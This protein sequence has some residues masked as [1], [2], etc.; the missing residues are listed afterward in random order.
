MHYAVELKK[1]ITEAQVYGVHSGRQ[2]KISP[3]G[4]GF[5]RIHVASARGES[6]APITFRLANATK[7]EIQG[8]SL[9][10]VYNDVYYGAILELH[11]DR[12]FFISESKAYQERFTQNI[13]EA[14]FG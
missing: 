6:P 2:Y 4:F 7:T 5:R 1:N 12:P 9:A 14:L 3:S 10:T 11:L 8:S 13:N